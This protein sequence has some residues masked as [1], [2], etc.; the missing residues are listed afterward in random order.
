MR[1]G[2]TWGLMGG[3]LHL[4]GTLA[5]QQAFATSGDGLSARYAAFS[6]WAPVE[7][8]GLSRRAATLGVNA[9][10]EMGER[11]QLALGVDQRFASR[12]R[13][14]SVMGSFRVVW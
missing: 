9:A 3:T 4:D 11:T 1:A 13:S 8:I 12:D 10:L 5:W 2:S 6:T 7:G 14:R